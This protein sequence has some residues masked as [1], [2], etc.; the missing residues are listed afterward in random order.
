MEISLKSVLTRGP[1]ASEG[2]SGPVGETE[3]FKNDEG[4]FPDPRGPEEVMD[5]GKNG[6]S[7]IIANESHYILWSGTVL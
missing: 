2:A 1:E 4:L 6:I 7:C 5:R 3:I